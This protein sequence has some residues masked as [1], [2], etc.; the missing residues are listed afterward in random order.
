[1]WVLNGDFMHP[2]IKKSING[3]SWHSNQ[4]KLLPKYYVQNASMEISLV[5]NVIKYN[6][7]SGKKII[8][9]KTLKYEG[10]DI[11]YPEDIIVLKYLLENK[12]AKLPELT[13]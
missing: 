5:K 7:I 13:L 3:T 8:P 2:L 6:S 11:N 1:M 10:F 4:T 9:F 12:L